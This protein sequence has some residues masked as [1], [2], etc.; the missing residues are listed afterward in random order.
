MLSRTAEIRLALLF[1]LLAALTTFVWAPLDSET[2]AF[3]E[4]R[5]QAYIGDA[6][7]PMVAGGGI[8][9][10]AAVHVVAQLGRAPEG[11]SRPPFDRLTLVF[12]VLFGGIVALSLALMYWA[13]PAALALFGPSGDEAPTYRQ[14]RSS[15]PWKYTGFVL[16]GFTLVFGLTSLLEG[17]MRLVRVLTSILAVLLLILVFDVPFDTILL[18]PNGDF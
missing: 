18:P 2:P 1:V 10:C 17:R 3:Y 15:F 12:F 7:L 13:G 9:L 6:L 4:F 16:G 11:D 8:L 5:R 14:M